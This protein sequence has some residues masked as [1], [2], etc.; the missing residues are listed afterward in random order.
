[1]DW[2]ADEIRRRRLR[3]VV[4]LIAEHLPPLPDEPVFR[5]VPR[6]SRGD[7]F[8]P[9]RL[10]RARCARRRYPAEFRETIE[11]HPLR[12]RA[13]PRS[14]AGCNSAA[15]GDGR[16]RRCARRGDEPE[17]RR[18]QS[19]GDLPVERQVIELVAVEMLGFPDEAMGLLV[20]GGSM[21]TLTAL[22]RRAPRQRAAWTSAPH[23]LRGA[24]RPFRFYQSPRRS[25]ARPQG[26]RAARLWQRR[27]SARYRPDGDYR[28]DPA[29]SIER[30]TEDRRGG[31]PPDCGRRHAPA[32]S[33]PVRSIRSRRSPL[34]AR[35]HD[36]WLHVDAAY[37]GPAIL[38]DDYA[39]RL[40]AHLA[41]RQ[42]GAR[43][44]QVDVRPVEAGL[45]M[46]RD[47]DAMRGAFSLVPPYIRAIGSAGDVTGLPWFSEYGFQQTRGLPRAEGLDDDASSSAARATRR[48]SRRTWPS[49]AIWPNASRSAPDLE[50]MAPPSLSVV[51]FR[52]SEA[53]ALDDEARSTRLNCARA[54][55]AAARRRGLPHRHRAA[56]DGSSC[57]PASSNYRSR[58]ADIDR[59]PAALRSIGRDLA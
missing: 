5:P 9:Q 48:R 13:S 12:Q 24:P 28:M 44:A 36:V 49:R 2:S 14:G 23:G 39:V 15:R 31:N 34:C 7:S 41:R 19:R 6:R 32:P 20:S 59:M 22:S 35:R 53:A 50:L 18:R 29:R 52:L 51:C 46:I 1:M 58:R 8:L 4:D 25:L 10:S 16:L 47:A 54:G 40:R 42:R 56:A 26:D 57:A 27:R 45:V 55:A 30:S 21:A 11:P 43:S 17:L 33:T 3:V 37:G 38:T